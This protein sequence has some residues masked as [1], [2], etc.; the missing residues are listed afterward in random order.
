[1]RVF[2][3]AAPDLTSKKKTLTPTLSRERGRGL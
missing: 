1:V 2:Y 3:F